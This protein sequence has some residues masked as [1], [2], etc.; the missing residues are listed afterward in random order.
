MNAVRKVLLAAFLSTLAAPRETAAWWAGGHEIVARAAAE[1]LPEEISR[2]YRES[3]GA[4]MTL[5][6]R[7]PVFFRKSGEALARSSA[8]PD[9]WKNRATPHL[10]DRERPEH[11]IDYELLAG[12]KLPSSRWKFFDLCAELEVAPRDVGLL[13]YAVVENVERLTLA[14]A[15]HRQQ[16]EDMHVQQKCLV[17]G[18]ILSHY[19]ADLAQPLHLTIHYDGRT[20]PGAP[21]PRTGI[22]NRT[23]VLIQALRFRPSELA[24]DVTPVVFDDLFSS[25]VEQMHEG[26]RYIDRV[27]ALEADLP[28]V[29]NGH[30]PESSWQPTDGVRELALNRTRA[31]TFLTASCWLTAWKQSWAIELPGWAKGG[32][33]RGAIGGGERRANERS[34]WGVAVVIV[35]LLTVGLVQYALRTRAGRR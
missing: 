15:Q 4:V 32:G 33:Q 16:P 5:P 24:E 21:S 25:V 27:Y 34:A 35:I 19:A 14:F 23:D 8:D 22:H 26:R 11:F 31:A 1:A 10:G 28:R 9:L 29:E 30:G 6:D 13:P 17:Y 18:G 3:G 12:R 20:S 7:L 2:V